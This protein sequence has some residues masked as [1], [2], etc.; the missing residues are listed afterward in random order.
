[1]KPRAIIASGILLLLSCLHFHSLAQVTP[2]YSVTSPEAS[3]LGEFGAVPVS[4]F[5]GI[6]NISIPL[7]E[8]K[9]GNYSIP[10]TADYHLA[11]VRP[12]DTAGCLGL[13][14]SLVADGVISRS[15]RGICDER[16][17]EN[18]TIGNGYYWHTGA[19]Q[20][21]VEVPAV[22]DSLTRE[23]SAG[24]YE[25][26]DS[27]F[28]L[29]ADEFSFNFLGYSGNF[30]LNEDGGWTV[31]SDQ[32]IKV[33]FD[34][35]TG[36]ANCQS[37][38]NRIPRISTWRGRD[39]Q[40]CFFIEF[41]L[42]TPDG[43]RYTFGGV[44][45]TDFSIP[46]YNRNYGELVATS[47]HL[48]RIVTPEGYTVSYNYLSSISEESIL[49]DLRYIPGSTSL[50]APE[51]FSLNPSY[52]HSNNIG[53]KAFT[54]FLQY[55]VNLSTIITPNE[56]ISFEY[57][58]D[59]HYGDILA[60]ECGEA[61]YWDQ[62][63]TD[64]LYRTDCYIPT[65]EDPAYQFRALFPDVSGNSPAEMRQGIADHLR[66]YFL[67]RISID[68]LRG[69]QDRS[70]FF[71]YAYQNRRKVDRIAWREG[72]SPVDPEYLSG[73]GLM[74]P[75]YS[76]PESTSDEDM[77]E[78]SFVYNEGKL[79]RN[80][81]FPRTDR[82]GYYDGMTWSPADSWPGPGNSPVNCIASMSETLR[83]VVYPTGGRSVFEYEGHS[84]S[85]S[86][87]LP[88]SS[89][90]LRGGLVGGL[91]IASISNYD[92]LDHLAGMIRYHYTDSLGSH[93]SSGISSPDYPD[94]IHYDAQFHDANSSQPGSG[95]YMLG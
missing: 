64:G 78:Y 33:E 93:I 60:N 1:M 90:T 16:R 2:V 92:R 12:N 6:P 85:K 51:G 35:S 88:G 83:E 59:I 30:Y 38:Q 19:M 48:K 79:P 3:G 57:H 24:K 27:W 18:A 87:P 9:F 89:P 13:G 39:E 44:N 5:T 72:I 11:S 47:W 94:R 63:G 66:S 75:V 29:A 40:N 20:E 65:S 61:L 55:C 56:R 73:G 71:S 22:F 14:W 74:I 41:T 36:F 21:I 42:I 8:I 28:E 49:A 67:Y 70:I 37:L 53:R 69:N 68:C 34:P 15:V 95:Y 7:Y 77:P 45:A 82:W 32:D 54:G 46:Y 81:V 50:S 31:V 10:I 17:S 25:G 43:V 84:C 52:L 80:T 4:Y 91:R 62:S 86:I 23:K 26:D 58:N 76:I